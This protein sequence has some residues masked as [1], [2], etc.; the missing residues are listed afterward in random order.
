MMCGQVAG[1]LLALHSFCG[2]D[3]PLCQRERKNAGS[4]ALTVT[5]GSSFLHIC[6]EE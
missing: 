1:A 2:K 3:S 6:I 4:F 5:V